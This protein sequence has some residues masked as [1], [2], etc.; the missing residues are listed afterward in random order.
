MTFGWNGTQRGGIVWRKSQIVVFREDKRHLRILKR[1]E[2]MARASMTIRGSIG[3]RSAL[4]ASSKSVEVD[5]PAEVP[6]K[7]TYIDRVRNYI[8]VEVIAFFIFA[9][10][11]VTLPKNLT[12]PAVRKCIADAGTDKAA[13]SKCPSVWSAM[14][15]NEWVALI[16]VLVGIIGTVLF[17]RT[18]YMDL[19]S[20]KKSDGTAPVALDWRLHAAIS[21][22]A[23]FIWIY[24]LDVKAMKVLAISQSAALS[25]LLL[26]SFTLFSGFVIPTKASEPDAA[27]GS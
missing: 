24:A 10:S 22:V 13:L 5:D 25:G 17:V 9:N 27:D 20:Q 26:G 11:L 3:D 14:D 1:I 21:V 19:H 18:A 7:Q 2:F 6:T 12:L 4:I 23:F 8:P 15:I 16:T